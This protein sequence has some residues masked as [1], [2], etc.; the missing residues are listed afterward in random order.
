MKDCWPE[1]FRVPLYQCGPYVTGCQKRA[2]ASGQFTKEP[3]DILC[4]RIVT[5]T[6]A[7]IKI[8]RLTVTLPLQSD[9]GL[10]ESPP[11]GSEPSVLSELLLIDFRSSSANDWR[12]FF[13][14]SRY[15]LIVEA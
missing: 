4:A 2:S 8:K 7:A 15:K 6:N 3:P 12:H 11:G 9:W 14:I 5:L 10:A 13:K 1:L